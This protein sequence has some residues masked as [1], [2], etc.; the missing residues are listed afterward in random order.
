V[1]RIEKEEE[2]FDYGIERAATRRQLHT[3]IQEE[4]EKCADYLNPACFKGA[5]LD[6]WWALARRFFLQ[7]I[8]WPLKRPDDIIMRNP[9]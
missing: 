8:R 7:H 9:V 6:E 4:D 2:E 1:R 5:D 3:A